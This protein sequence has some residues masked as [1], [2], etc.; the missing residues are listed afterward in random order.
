MDVTS[1]T[2]G[3]VL[4][5][6]EAEL[7]GCEFVA[8]D[9]EMTGIGLPNGPRSSFGDTPED[10]YAKMLPVASTYSIVQMGVCL[11]TKEGKGGKKKGGDGGAQTLLARP[12]N[13]YTFAE[14]PGPDVTLSLSAM[15]FLKKQ[16]MDF[17]K[18]I[19]NGVSFTN[20]AGEAY[21]LK[22]QEQERE[23]D[24]QDAAGGGGGEERSKMKL[25]RKQD[26]DFV[27][28]QMDTLE[29]WYE[30]KNG[31][32]EHGGS[33][34]ELKEAARR[35]K[36][37]LLCRC[38]AFLRRAMYEAIEAAHPELIKETR[39]GQIVVLRLTDAEKKE[40]EEAR[41]ADRQ[42]RFVAA[43]GLRRVFKALGASGKPLVVHNGMYDLMFMMDAFHGPL[44][45]T[46]AEFKAQLAE[47]FPSGIIYDTKVRVN[48]WFVL[49]VVF[50]I[51][52][53]TSIHPPTL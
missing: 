29:A 19:R 15:H 27:K 25:N 20:A 51:H 30:G 50:F 1:E 34:E 41:E 31:V 8:I 52:M 18:W 2:F 24:R 5:E 36:E 42:A 6:L 40:R 3:T 11:F 39:N 33:D 28:T 13:F 22:K 49:C 32:D 26:I 16:G 14:E 7:A 45:P 12:Y 48:V 4:P 9:F 44:A 17:N 10:R 23:W 47:C 43:T 53:R 21:L 35:K 46:L 37:L 38:N